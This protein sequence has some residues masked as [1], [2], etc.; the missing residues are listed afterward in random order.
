MRGDEAEAERLHAQAL[1]LR[2][3]IRYL[4]GVAVTAGQ[5]GALLTVQGRAPEAQALLEESRDLSREQDLPGPLTLAECY[6]ALLGR[7]TPAAAADALARGGPR[8]GHFDR[9]EAHYVLWQAGHEGADLAAAHDLLQHALAHAPAERR[10][11]MAQAVPLHRS[12]VRAWQ[13]RNP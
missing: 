8:V 2:R 1:G 7:T 4:R 6:L 13:A 3:E 12:I 11:A 9:M 10:A 5:L